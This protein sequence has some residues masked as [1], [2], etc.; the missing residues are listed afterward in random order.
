MKLAAPFFVFF[1]II[2]AARA[3]FVIQQKAYIDLGVTNFGDCSATM[4]I[5]GDKIRV[6]SVCD[7]SSP[8]GNIS[9][10]MDLSA[11]ELTELYHGEKQMLKRKVN[12]DT[13]GNA[14]IPKLQD[15]GK[16]ETVAGFAA[17][18]YT[19]TNND[20]SGTVWVAKD[21]PNYSKIQPQ[22]EK[23][24]KMSADNEPDAYALGMVVKI[25]ETQEG[26][27]NPVM[28]FVSMKEEPVDDS[29][30]EIPKDYQEVK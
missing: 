22:L 29:V 23:M 27:L 18:I 10:I 9:T 2:A 17:E 19:W 15:T 26:A 20:L 8:S 14:T 24:A 1:F 12:I 3:D 16:T 13:A 11:R 21:F 28:T 6:D 4:K 7:L 30:F 5:K 25:K